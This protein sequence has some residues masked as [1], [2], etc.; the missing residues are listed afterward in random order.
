MAK[1]DVRARTIDGLKLCYKCRKWLSESEFGVSKREADGL[2]YQCKRCVR[3]PYLA[4]YGLTQER[5]D[6]LLEAQGGVCA[7]CQQPPSRAFDIDHDHNCCPQGS[8]CGKCVRGLLCFNCNSALGKLKDDVESL[9]RAV[10][11]LTR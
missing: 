10:T 2:N 6:E 3:R 4:K 7:I 5:Y 1:R 11:Y 8:S 9:K